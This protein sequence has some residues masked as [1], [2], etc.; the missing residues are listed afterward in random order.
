MAK[1]LKAAAEHPDAGAASIPN[2]SEEDVFLHHLDRIRAQQAKTAGAKAAYDAEKKAETALFRAAKADGFSRKEL[3]QI[4][5]DGQA[6]RRDLVAEEERRAKLR[7]WAGLPAGSQPDLFDLPSPARDEVDAEAEGYQRG[8]RGED[9][10][11]PDHIS[12][13]H[14]QAFMKGWHQAQKRRAEAL[15]P[16]DDGAGEPAEL[17]ETEQA[18]AA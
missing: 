18:E 6:T 15:G 10:T 3:E 4:L 9:P 5:E 7:A 2:R 11:V 16:D 12:P 14:T 1:R 17:V 8:L 13:N